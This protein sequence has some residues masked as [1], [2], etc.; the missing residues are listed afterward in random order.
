MVQDMSPGLALHSTAGESGASNA[1]IID[2]NINH[3]SSVG[4]QSSACSALFSVQESMVDGVSPQ[5]REQDDSFFSV[6]RYLGKISDMPGRC[7]VLGR[8][9]VVG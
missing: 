4:P 7:S 3:Q 8:F 9:S 5:L 1:D 2:I 6:L